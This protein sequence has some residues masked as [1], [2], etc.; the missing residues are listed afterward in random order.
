MVPTLYFRYAASNE[1]VERISNLWRI[2]ENRVA[3]G[4][5]GTVQTSG[6]YSTQDH[7]GDRGM[8]F[9]MGLEYSMDQL[10]NAAKT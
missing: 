10:T 4:K 1:Q 6:I 8:P 9:N 7:V 2:H 3:R 5:G